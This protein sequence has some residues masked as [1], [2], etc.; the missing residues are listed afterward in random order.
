MLLTLMSSGMARK[1]ALMRSRSELEDGCRHV[2]PMRSAR[3]KR[4]RM[5]NLARRL[6]P[7]AFID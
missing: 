6:H 5:T 1:A 4:R 7:K 3:D 2:S